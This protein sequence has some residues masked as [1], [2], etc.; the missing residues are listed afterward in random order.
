MQ[1]EKMTVTQALTELKLL[2]KRIEKTIS[3]GTYIAAIQEKTSAKSIE[4]V[5]ANITSSWQRSNDLITR[6]NAIKGAVAASNAT[7][8]VVVGT[9]EYTVAMA[10]DAKAHFMVYRKKLLEALTAQTRTAYNNYNNMTSKVEKDAMNLVK[11]SGEDTSNPD[12]AKDLDIY[13]NYQK[14]NA[15]TMVDPLGVDKLLVQM[16]DDIDNFMVNVDTA[17]SV[18]NATTTI[19]IGYDAEG[20]ILIGDEAKTAMEAQEH[21]DACTG[22]RPDMALAPAPTET[23]AE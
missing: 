21:V 5:K 9:H 11:S 16:A 13:K 8:K 23:T 18:A 20:T 19:Y 6:Y 3:D 15:V 2:G 1:Y 14:A 17:L 22:C 12:A 4:D 10:I 7:A